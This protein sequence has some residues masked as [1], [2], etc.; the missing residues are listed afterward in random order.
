MAL[1]YYHKFESSNIDILL[2]ISKAKILFFLVSML[3]IIGCS[4]GSSDDGGSDGAEPVISIENT[5]LD[6]GNSGTSEMLFV[7]SLSKAADNIV[8]VDY[9]TADG[10]ATTAD[11]DYTAISNSL[12]IPAGE[13]SATVAVVI[14][15]DSKVENTETFMLN[16]SNPVNATLSSSTAIGMI[17]SDEVPPINDTGIVSCS[18]TFTSNTTCPQDGFPGQDAERGRDATD[19]DSSDGYAGFSFTQ[20]DSNGNPLASKSN[21]YTTTPWPCVKDNVTGL[22]WEVKERGTSLRN[23]AH[24]YTW[25]NSSGTNDG[26]N[27]G[28]ENNGNC[29]DSVNCD[30][31]KYVVQVNAATLCGF[32]DW[33]L[34]TREELRSISNLSADTINVSLDA[35]YFP[36]TQ[37]SIY[38]SSTAVAFESLN[39]WQFDF[40][41][42]RAEHF[43]K[44]YSFY[45][46]LVRP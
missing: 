46:K 30:T 40:Y 17:I 3:S 26:G 45:V 22:I 16:L 19:N 38:W 7:I 37:G 24:T 12:S 5:S 23:M 36:N 20:L 4:G 15:G 8:S 27:A 35:D 41:K 1:N 14:N 44:S 25:Y 13:T 21:D 28:T 43:D 10:A 42:G 6:E 31:E 11:N 39:A 32:S 18:S 9:S 33:R 2:I 34:P 29:F